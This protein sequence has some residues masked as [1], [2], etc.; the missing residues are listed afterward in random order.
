MLCKKPWIIPIPGS[1]KEERIRENLNSQQ[2]TLSAEEIA[3]IDAL[4]NTMEMPVY[5]QEKRG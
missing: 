1:R 3:R 2:V 5:G 4:L